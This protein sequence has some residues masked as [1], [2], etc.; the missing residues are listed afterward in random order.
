MKK[1]IFAMTCLFFLFQEI[2]AQVK[3]YGTSETE[4]IFSFADYRK[5]GQS[6]NTPLRF[7][8]FL[9]LGNLYHMD[10]NKNFGLFTGY[11]LRN[12]GFSSTEGDSTIKRR[13]YYL[14]VP[15]GIKIG[16][17]GNGTY[18]YL[19]AEA[20][21]ALNYKEKLF[22]AGKKIESAKFNTW[23]S[24]RT[25]LFMPSVFLG[26]NTKSGMNVKF[27]YYLQDFYN[28]NFTENGVK[29]YNNVE[30]SQIFYFSIGWNVSN[31]RKKSGGTAKQTFNKEA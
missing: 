5:A 19:G 9:H 29:I 13:N 18:V 24:E 3:T 11:G 2:K 10:L 17:V 31:A 27:R 4:L 28:K 8:C 12:I 7:S 20:E 1:I 23:F 22:V 15:V 14:G 26:L 16:E 21:L 25:N 6:I 30:S